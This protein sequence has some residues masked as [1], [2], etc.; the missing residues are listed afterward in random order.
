MTPM[1]APPPPLPFPQPQLTTGQKTGRFFI[2]IGLGFV[3][4]LVA[5]GIVLIAG[6]IGGNVASALYSVAIY[7]P[8]LLGLGFL[9]LM[10]YFLTQPRFR[11]IGYGMLTVLV[12]LPVI[13][14]VGCIVI[15]S[16]SSF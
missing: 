14:A 7:A 9:G 5:L 11:F 2:G 1:S 8:C 6:G 16:Q 13:A 12:A 3:P 4:L 15:I 10:I